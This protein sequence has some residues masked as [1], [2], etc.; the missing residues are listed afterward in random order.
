MDPQQLLAQ[1]TDNVTVTRVFGEPIQHGDTL[2]VPVARI[3]GAAGG[4]S[5]TGPSNEGSGSGGGGGFVAAPAGVFVIKAGE[6][7]WHP[8]LDVTRI[9]L[10]G[11]AVGVVLALVLRSILRRR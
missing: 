6:A 4:G 1:V 7:H 11:Q 3:R 9:V 2:V 5:G 10:G 8:A